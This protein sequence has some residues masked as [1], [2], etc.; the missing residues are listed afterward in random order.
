M[1]IKN[2]KGKQLNYGDVVS[3]Y[4]RGVY[5]IADVDVFPLDFETEHNNI[6]KL[7]TDK[8]I[9]FYKNGYVPDIKKY[10]NMFELV[11]AD[12]NKYWKFRNGYTFDKNFAYFK[13]CN[14]QNAELIAKELLQIFCK[15]Y[16]L[17]I[18]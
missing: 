12:N 15:T 16:N 17:T 2:S 6:K 3:V 18:E 11:I 7:L 4:K 14:K 13:T 9:E 10:N 1:V 8:Y 5:Y